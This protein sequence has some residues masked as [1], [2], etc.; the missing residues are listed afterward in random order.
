VS[1]VQ[2]FLQYVPIARLGWLE[3]GKESF[4]VLALQPAEDRIDVSQLSDGDYTDFIVQWA[5]LVASSHLRSAG[6]KGSAD[7]AKLIEHGR[8]FA[9]H[10][11][12]HLLAC[13]RRMAVLQNRAYQQFK[14]SRL[15]RA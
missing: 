14:K 15:G 8:D 4:V 6:W 7:L 10:A 13:A 9:P 2:Y 1:T 12:R 5:R 11:Q 3:S